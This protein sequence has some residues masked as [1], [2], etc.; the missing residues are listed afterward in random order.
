MCHDRF[1]IRVINH[2][3]TIFLGTDASRGNLNRRIYSIFSKNMVYVVS[4]SQ[5]WI[6]VIT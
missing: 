3:Q 6:N 2:Y 1:S 4:E 5:Q